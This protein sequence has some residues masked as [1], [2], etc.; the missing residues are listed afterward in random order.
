M[1]LVFCMF[2]YLSYSIKY[3]NTAVTI[4]YNTLLIFSKELKLI[5]DMENNIHKH[6][7]TSDEF[8]Q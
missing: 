8:V 6:C 2:K 7:L 5:Y 1:C 4:D 3:T